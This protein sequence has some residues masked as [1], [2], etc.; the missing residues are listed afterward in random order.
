M[1]MNSLPQG[2]KKGAPRFWSYLILEGAILLAIG[3][4][5]VEALWPWLSGQTTVADLAHVVGSIVAFATTILSWNC[6]KEFNR[7]AARSIQTEI[8]NVE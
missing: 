7:A 3:I 8:E 4:S 2:L 6:I 5:L 1:M